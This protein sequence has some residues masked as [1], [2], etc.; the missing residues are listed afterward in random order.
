M[1]TPALSDLVLRSTCPECNRSGCAACDGTGYVCRS[2]YSEKSAVGLGDDS[3]A[4]C[5]AKESALLR[6]LRLSQ[7]RLHGLAFFVGPCAHGRDPWDRCPECGN[8][9]APEALYAAWAAVTQEAV[10]LKAELQFERA[11]REKA[12]AA[13]RD[14][15]VA[16]DRLKVECDRLRAL[17]SAPAASRV[18][19][20]L[21]EAKHALDGLS[22]EC[23]RCEGL[24]AHPAWRNDSCVTEA[25]RKLKEVLGE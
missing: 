22:C 4:A 11:R 1:T 9:S 3:C 24:P 10:A 5:E 12:E 18:L 25:L 19:E 16:F 15:L 2:P 8:K 7:A 17:A 23:W 13:Y 6:E 20:A 21:R 14:G